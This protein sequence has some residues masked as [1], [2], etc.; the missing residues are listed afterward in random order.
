MPGEILYWQ[1]RVMEHRCEEKTEYAIHEV[2]FDE[3][4]TPL[5]FSVDALSPRFET[6]VGLKDYLQDCLQQDREEFVMGDCSYTYEK[7]QIEFWLEF[8]DEQILCYDTK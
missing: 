2:Y 8:M 7:S 1:P 6:V 4:R 3:N 5:T